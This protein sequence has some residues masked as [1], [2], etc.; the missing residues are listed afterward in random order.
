M[1][2]T[3]RDSELRDYLTSEIETLRSAVFRAGVL[4]AKALGP[5]ADTHLENVLRYIAVTPELEEATYV[6]RSR[7]AVFARALYAQAQIAAIEQ[8]RREALAAI[9]AFAAAVDA[10]ARAGM[11]PTHRHS[12]ADCLASTAAS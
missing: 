11:D 8:A 10:A 1:A 5:C 4:N 12:D 3:L 7:T 6:A 9:D 2:D